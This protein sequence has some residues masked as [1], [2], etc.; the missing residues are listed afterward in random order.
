MPA[1]ARHPDIQY[2]YL[3]KKYD[4]YITLRLIVVTEHAEIGLHLQ[5]IADLTDQ[6]SIQC[7]VSDTSQEAGG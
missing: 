5:D 3:V 7:N 2:K 4:P 6:R 1:L